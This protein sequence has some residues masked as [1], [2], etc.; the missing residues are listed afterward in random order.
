MKTWRLLPPA[1]SSIFVSPLVRQLSWQGVTKCATSVFFGALALSGALYSS[2]PSAATSGASVSVWVGPRIVATQSQTGNGE[3]V[4]A[5]AAGV[6]PSS[7][8]D[9]FMNGQSLGRA[10]FLGV[11]GSA[12]ST[13]IAGGYR[14]DAAAEWSD[15]FI[16]QAGSSRAGTT[17]KF[18]GGVFV[19][20]DLSID[21]FLG[22][23]Y[24]D[25]LVAANIS[26]NGT[27]LSNL[28][29]FKGGYDVPFVLSGP[30]GFALFFDQVPFT[31]GQPISI[32]G[33]LTVSASV[34]IIDAGATARAFAGYGQ[35]MHWSG[36]SKVIDAAGQPLGLDDYSAISD[37]TGVDY[38]R[39][40]PEPDSI[41]L[42]ALGLLGICWHQRRGI[43]SGRRA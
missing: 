12:R 37:N 29:T 25:T 23:F 14:A 31:F 34:N 41:T 18:S 20:G 2:S 1:A 24:G 33:A 4:V 8:G 42:L 35:T 17:G 15:S 26:V 30:E 7:F 32:S 28:T 38:A 11:V 16:V 6:I 39:P 13:G 3:S 27:T 9:A 43:G 19:N 5:S 40:I 22:R 10:G 21:E 36:F